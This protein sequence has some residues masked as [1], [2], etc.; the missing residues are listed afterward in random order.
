MNHPSSEEIQLR[1]HQVM[2]GSLE[3]SRRILGLTIDLC[4]F[5]VYFYVFLCFL[6]L[7]Y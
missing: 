4:I 3:N 6:I 1:A 2:D 7:F 5:F